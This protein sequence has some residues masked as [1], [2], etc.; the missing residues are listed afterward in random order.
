[1]TI[2]VDLG[3]K[4]TKQ[5]TK[6]VNLKKISRQQKSRKVDF[7]QACK[8]SNVLRRCTVT[9]VHSH[10]LIRGYKILDVRVDAICKLETLLFVMQVN[11]CNKQPLVS[12]LYL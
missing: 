8:E 9:A 2:V 3:C 12:I 5:Q 7:F 4:A 6:K 11:I 10:V 1:M